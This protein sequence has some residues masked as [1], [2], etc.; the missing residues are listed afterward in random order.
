VHQP[1]R[2]TDKIKTLDALA[3]LVQQAKSRGSTTVFTNGCFDIVHS[4]HVKL[5]EQCRQAGDGLIVGLN[6]DASVRQLKGPGRPIV[7]QEQRAQVVAALESVDY[8]VIFDELD[9]LQIITRLV[10]DV[11]IK[12]GDWTPETIIGRDVVEAAGGIVFAIP[13]MDNV[14]TTDIANKMKAQ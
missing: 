4:G 8:V 11:L 6:S 5:L 2:L 14:S 9:P 13:L 12:G 3:P 7:P 1:R 10:P